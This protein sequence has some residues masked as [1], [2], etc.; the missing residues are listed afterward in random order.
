MQKLLFVLIALAIMTACSQSG[1]KSAGNNPKAD[2]EVPQTTGPDGADLL[3]ALQGRW[4]S[5]ADANYVM[6]VTDDRIKY[7]T[8]GQVNSETVIEIDSPCQTVACKTDTTD[9]TD[10]WCFVEKGKFDAQCVLVMACDKSMLKFSY[11][12][13]TAP[14]SVFNKI[15]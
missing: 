15:D 7:W 3:R 13:A 12:G 4:Q 1:S 11:I 10:G 8:N 5:A 14:P 2:T 9:L 6:E